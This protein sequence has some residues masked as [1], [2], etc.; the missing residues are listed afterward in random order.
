MTSVRLFLIGLLFLSY[1]VFAQKTGCDVKVADLSGSYSGG[2]KNGLAHGKGIA[3]GTD[4]Y[5]GRFSNGMP[6]GKGIYTWSDGKYYEGQWRDGKREGDGKMVYRDS[7][8][9]GIWKDDTLYEKKVIPP[10]MIIR[11]LSVS[12][13]TVTQI[14]KTDNKIRI[15][16]F[17]GGVENADMGELSLTYTSGNEYQSGSFVGIQNPTFPVDIKIKFSALNYFHTSSFNV[18]FEFTINEPGTW[19]VA[20]SY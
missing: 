8:V 15:R 5:E 10:Y 1:P 19:D 12:R 6:D 20:I 13:Y 18:I 14:S 3:Q 2:C 11:A 4:R 16:F 7:I 9:S 17:R